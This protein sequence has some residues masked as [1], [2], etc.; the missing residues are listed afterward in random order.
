MTSKTLVCHASAEYIA[1]MLS[2]APHML[3]HPNI[4]SELSGVALFN[5]IDEATLQQFAQAASLRTEPKGKILFIQEDE[6]E[7]VYLI[8]RGWVKMFRETMDGAEA[9]IDVMTAGHMFGDNAVFENDSYSYSAQVVEQV[10]M[11]MFPVSVLKKAIASNPSIALNMLSSMSRHRQQQHLEIEHLNLQ[12]AP[13]RIGCFLL[14]LCPADVGQSLNLNLP[15]DKTLI[16]ARLGMKPETFSRAL[17]VLKK[18]GLIEITGA[19]VFIPNVPHLVTY[20]CDHC[21][22][23][24]PCEDLKG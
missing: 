11:I 10:Q 6:A 9:V 16:A 14:R 3:D 15:Y 7:W 13:Q 5:G 24:F 8:Q 18:D 2:V 4:V 22:T 21:S 19:S 20:T 12:N 23:A 17:A 1:H